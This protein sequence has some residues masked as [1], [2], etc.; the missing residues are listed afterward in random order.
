[1]DPNEFDPFGDDLEPEATVTQ[2]ATDPKAHL[3][4][5]CRTCTLPDDCPGSD[6]C[7]GCRHGHNPE[8]DYERWLENGAGR[9][10]DDIAEELY[11]NPLAAFDPQGGIDPETGSSLH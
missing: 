3:P 5:P 11:H 8:E 6:P 2:E 4:E 9:V 7:Y 10:I 1:M